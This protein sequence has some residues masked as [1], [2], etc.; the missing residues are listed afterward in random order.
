[1]RALDFGSLDQLT[2]QYGT[3]TQLSGM[4]ESSTTNPSVVFKAKDVR[5]QIVTLSPDSVLS[6]MGSR[7]PLPAVYTDPS[8]VTTIT[9]GLVGRSSLN[10]KASSNEDLMSNTSND[11]A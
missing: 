7:S 9:P 11:D 3:N 6:L 1:M 10:M 5:Q 2:K 4:P 8:T